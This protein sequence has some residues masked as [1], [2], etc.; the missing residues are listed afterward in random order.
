MIVGTKA[1]PLDKLRSEC[2]SIDSLRAF[3]LS[4][5]PRYIQHVTEIVDNQKYL[6]A[7]EVRAMVTIPYKRRKELCEGLLE[8]VVLKGT[9]NTIVD[10]EDLMAS[11]NMSQVFKV[12]FR[13]EIEN[14]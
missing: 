8:G 9:I 2:R 14:T 12:L 5:V 7:M 1:I 6:V 10:V 3:S 13:E 11:I 4:L